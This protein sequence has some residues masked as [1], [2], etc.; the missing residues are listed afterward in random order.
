M[1]EEPRLRE[2]FEGLK[3]SKTMKL[4]APMKLNPTACQATLLLATLERANAACHT[5]SA[6]AWKEQTFRQYDLHKALYAG[7]KADFSLSAQMVVRALGKVAHTYKLDRKT[8]RT[9]SIEMDRSFCSPPATY[10]KRKNRPHARCWAWIWASSNWLRTA[11]S[12]SG[13]QVERTRRHYEKM[14]AGLQRVSTRSAKRKLKKVSGRERRFKKDTNHVISKRLVAKA[15]DTNRAIALEELSGIRERTTVR[16]GQRARHSK[17]A[18]SELRHFITYKAVRSGITI[19]VVD[20]RGTSR[21]C[22]ACEH[23]EKAN[24]KGQSEFVCRN[25]GHRM[26]ADYNA[27]LNI[28]ARGVV[29]LPMVAPT[30]AL[31]S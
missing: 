13:Q 5:I 2:H 14:R 7:V 16:K 10:Q 4:T 1:R 24:R 23:S 17:W 31:A 15:K 12:F 18:F 3:G 28:R 30:L 19:V 27:A 29:N 20:P 6:W 25:C 21:C 22:S 26:N 9:L 11:E 8:Q